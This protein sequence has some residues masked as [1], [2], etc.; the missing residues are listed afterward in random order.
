M[1][2][3]STSLISAS[4]ILQPDISSD[5]PSLTD[6]GSALTRLLYEH[7]FDQIKRT[8]AADSGSDRLSS[9]VPCVSAQDCLVTVSCQRQDKDALLS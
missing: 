8:V 6:W 4:L 9:H 5:G 7:D 3:N 1:F 2:C